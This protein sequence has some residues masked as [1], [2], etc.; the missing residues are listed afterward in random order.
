MLETLLII[1]G[2]VFVGMLFGQSMEEDRRAEEAKAEASRNS[3][4]PK[5]EAEAWVLQQK[6]KYREELECSVQEARQA[7]KTYQQITD[8]LTA[9]GITW[10]RKLERPF[11][12][13]GAEW[14]CISGEKRSIAEKHNIYAQLVLLA[15]NTGLCMED[16]IRAADTQYHELDAVFTKGAQEGLDIANAEREAEREAFV[17]AQRRLKHIA[18]S[19]Y[20]VQ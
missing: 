2:I 6:S 15:L 14:R 1:G 11:Y 18:D 12:I 7:P 8:E 3:Y 13:R 20:K 10:G 19:I 16:A 17:R 5:A 9:A 4:D